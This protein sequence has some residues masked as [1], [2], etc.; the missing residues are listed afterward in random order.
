MFLFSPKL[1]FW[2]IKKLCKVHEPHRPVAKHRVLSIQQKI[3]VW[4]FG[5]FTCPVERYILG[6]QTWSKP[7]RVWLLFFISRIQ[8]SSTGDNNF[9]KWR[10]TFPSDRPKWLDRS[11][12]WLDP[13]SWSQIFLRDQTKMVCSIWCTNRNFRNFGLNGK[14][15]HS[16][17]SSLL[18][19]LCLITCSLV[20]GL[21]NYGLFC[22]LVR[23]T[24]SL[25][26]V[27]FNLIPFTQLLF[28]KTLHCLHY[29]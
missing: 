27:V 8:K 9:V 21:C 13:Q 7:P 6:A 29:G 11:K 24:V 2:R 22:S 14:C 17:F 3:L 10:G 5:N 23:K 4:N 18:Q 19:N 1:V 28:N 12:K 20:L 25:H 26:R 15:L 16:P